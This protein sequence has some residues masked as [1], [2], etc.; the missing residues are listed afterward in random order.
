MVGHTLCLYLQLVV[1]MKQFDITNHEKPKWPNQE[2]HSLHTREISLSGEIPSSNPSP[3]KSQQNLQACTISFGHG[4][5]W[6]VAIGSII[7]S[8]V[9]IVKPRG[10]V[11]C[12]AFHKWIG[13]VGWTFWL[14][15]ERRGKWCLHLPEALGVLYLYYIILNSIHLCWCHGVLKI[16]LLCSSS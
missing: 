13:V 14:D 2:T 3:V 10:H 9:S 1:E 4:N 11:S 8:N 16:V 12:L 6:S 5:M 7:G 15:K